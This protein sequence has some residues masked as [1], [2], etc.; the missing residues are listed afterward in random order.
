MPSRCFHL[1]RKIRNAHTHAAGLVR[2]DLVTHHA[3]LTTT[4]Q[5]TWSTLTGQIFRVPA[6]GDS[7]ALVFRG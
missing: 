4:Q 3:S 6:V 7:A 5:G 1:T 2:Q